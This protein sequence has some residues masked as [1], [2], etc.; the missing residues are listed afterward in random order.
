R[1]S[2]AAHGQRIR[3]STCFR[4]SKQNGGTETDSL[5]REPE[6]THLAGT[7]RGWPRN[8]NRSLAASVQ[9]LQIESCRPHASTPRAARTPDH[10]MGQAASPAPFRDR[11]LRNAHRAYARNLSDHS[12]D[13]T[14]LG[15]CEK[16]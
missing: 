15:K 3:I 7:R 16:K 10:L 9:A 4:C 14:S 13:G 1:V 6:P 11:L 2:V 12:A 5:L 8:R